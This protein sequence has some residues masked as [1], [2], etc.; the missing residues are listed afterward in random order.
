[1][2][3][4][5]RGFSGTIGGGALEYSAIARARGMLADQSRDIAF[6]DFPLGPALGQCCGG[7]VRIGYE[8]LE[9]RDLD[10]LQHA[11]E[12]V[13][14]GEAVI[15]E[16][17]LP[18]AQNDKT[19]RRAFRSDAAGKGACAFA[20]LGGDGAA[21][22][23]VMPPLEQCSGFREIIADDRVGVYVFG[24]G[25]VGSAIVAI[26]EALPATVAW[27]DR[28]ADFF[29]ESVGDNVSIAA[30]DNETG[31]AASAP[32]GACYFVLTHSHQ[33]DYELVREILKRGDSIYC[34]LIGSKTKRARFERRLRRAGVE[35]ASLSH[36]SCPIGGG[37]LEGKSPAIIALAAVH[38]MFLARQAHERGKQRWT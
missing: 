4:T 25:H 22:S 14:D 12:I 13:K 24:A 6:E 5:A 29:P 26:L 3:V 32:A 30:T 15:L 37:G 11:G 8:R 38:E 1:M 9:P 17:S 23:D 27:I 28:R 20:F 35:E 7:R 21:L 18:H 19:Q 10:W 16:R 31:V 34:G 36:L 2:L 33:L